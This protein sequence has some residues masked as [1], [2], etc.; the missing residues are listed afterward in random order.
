MKMV[1]VVKSEDVGA[2]VI[3]TSSME[4]VSPGVVIVEVRTEVKE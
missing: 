2:V 3:V 1:S 4:G